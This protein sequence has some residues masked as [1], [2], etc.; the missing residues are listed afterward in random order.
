MHHLKECVS[1]SPLISPRY[2]LVGIFTRTLG[3]AYDRSFT[4]VSVSA[5]GEGPLN[6]RFCQ[7]YGVQMC[8]HKDRDPSYDTGS[9]MR[10]RILGRVLRAERT[11]N[12]RRCPGT[13]FDLIRAITRAHTGLA[14]TPCAGCNKIA[15]QISIGSIPGFPSAEAY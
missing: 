7:S 12:V 14:R 6:R 11:R 15:T 8:G 13:F 10:V 1:R 9:L 2:P 5:R 4:P 3:E